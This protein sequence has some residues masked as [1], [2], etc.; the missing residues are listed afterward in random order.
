MNKLLIL[1]MTLLSFLCTAQKVEVFDSVQFPIHGVDTNSIMNRSLSNAKIIGLGE[2]THTVGT[3]F[4]SKVQMIKYLHNN[5][6]YDIVA[7]EAGFYDCY[8]AN[9]ILKTDSAKSIHLFRALFSIWWCEEVKE[10]FEYIIETQKTNRPISI[11]GFDDQF[12]GFYSVNNFIPDFKKFTDSLLKFT[13]KKIDSFNDF[14]QTLRKQIKI[15]NSYKTLNSTDTQ[16]LFKKTNYIVNLIDSNEIL[17]K[18]SY[19]QFWKRNCL[20]IQTEY[21]DAFFGYK[22]SIRDSTMFTNVVW[23]SENQFVDKK[24]VIW[25]A[26][27]HLIYGSNFIKNKTYQINTMGSYLKNKYAENYFSIVFTPGFGRGGWRSKGIFSYKFRMPKKNSFEYFINNKFQND[28]VYYPFNYE[29][30]KELIYRRGIT[31]AKFFGK[32]EQTMNITKITDAVFYIKEMKAPT[33][34]FSLK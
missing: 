31:K 29:E 23:I 12:S 4:K 11:V 18:N 28:F 25:A 22:N 21:R 16:L 3:T 1:S 10:L 15:S 19:F 24:V 9:E 27:I 20:N 26:S 33:Y 5:L 7:F 17:S 8:K 6:G 34:K 13:S 32:K 14:E 2:S 30:N